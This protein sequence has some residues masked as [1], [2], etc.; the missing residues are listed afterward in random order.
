MNMISLGKNSFGQKQNETMIPETLILKLV[1]NRSLNKCFPHQQP[2]GVGAC[3][4]KLDV[5]SGV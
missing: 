1:L 5:H 2:V 3:P 4:A